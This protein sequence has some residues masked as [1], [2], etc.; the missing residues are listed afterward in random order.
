MLEGTALIQSNQTKLVIGRRNVWVGVDIPSKTSICE[1]RGK[2][3]SKSLREECLKVTLRV[4]LGKEFW[5]DS[6]WPKLTYSPTSQWWLRYP[7]LS[8]VL[9]VH[10]FTTNYAISRMWCGGEVKK[11]GDARS[12]G[13]LVT[14]DR[15]SK[16]RSPSPKPLCS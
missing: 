5:W 13:V 16:L 4:I 6:L 14:C 3:Q 1:A 10:P 7:S 2:N 11:G 8:A 9:T 15:G 12:V